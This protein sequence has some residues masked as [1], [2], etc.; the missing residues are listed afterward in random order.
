MGESMLEDRKV[1]SRATNSGGGMVGGLD[2]A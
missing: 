2:H 1:K